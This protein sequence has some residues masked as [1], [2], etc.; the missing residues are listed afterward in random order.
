MSSQVERRPRPPSLRQPSSKLERLVETHLWARVLLG[1]LFGI[2]TGLAIGPSFGLVDPQSGVVLGN[3]LAFPGRLS[4]ASIQ[5]IVV[6]LVF[7]SIIRGL[8]ANDDPEA[9]KANGIRVVSFFGRS[10]EVLLLA[11]STS[12]SAAVM[13]LSLRTAEGSSGSAPPSRRSSSRSG[14]RP[15]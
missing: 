2:A 11:C 10:R 1:M 4:L 14:R 9:L 8:A 15:T 13:P 12:G 6:P 3:W 5:M 7:A